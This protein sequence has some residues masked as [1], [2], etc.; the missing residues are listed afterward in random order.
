[1]RRIVLLSLALALPACTSAENRVQEIFHHN[2]V[3]LPVGSI[4]LAT[5]PVNTILFGPCREEFGMSV[6]KKGTCNLYYAVRSQTAPW[7]RT[8]ANAQQMAYQPGELQ[9]SRTLG[10][11]TECYVISGTPRPVNL[12]APNM[13][14]N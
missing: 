6:D 4:F 8:A 12:I 14:A 7:D 3:V 5:P 1:M 13:G 10:G 2:Q 9:C 11:R